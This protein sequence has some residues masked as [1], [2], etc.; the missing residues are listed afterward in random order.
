MFVH[1]I[2]LPLRK[3]RLTAETI[4]QPIPTLSGRQ[5][6]VAKATLSSDE[7]ATQRELF[8]YREELFKRVRGRWKEVRFRITVQPSAS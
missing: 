7:E 4:S 3:F 5:F 1:R 8:W 2:L 6:V